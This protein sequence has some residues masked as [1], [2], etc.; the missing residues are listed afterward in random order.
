[1]LLVTFLFLLGLI[2]G[3][4][5]NVVIA[6][7]KT[8][9]KQNPKLS[10]KRSKCPHCG[11]V[12]AWYDNIPLL[13][14]ILLKGRCRHCGKKISWQ[15]PLVELVTA[16]LVVG[17]LV[18]DFSALSIKEI[19]ITTMTGVG[20]AF[21]IFQ[22]SCVFLMIG[23]LVA[24]F[25]YDLKHYLIPDR[26]VLVGVIATLIY[27]LL[28]DLNLVE[29]GL[30]PVSTGF[31]LNSAT[32]SGFL[33]ALIASGFFFCLVYFSKEKWMG[34]GD[35][36]L[37][38]FMGLVLGFPTIL[39]GLFIAYLTG[40]VVGVSL[41]AFKKKK[42]KSEIPFGPFLCLGTYIAL[43]FGRQIIVWYLKIMS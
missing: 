6:R 7:N 33:G 30:K 34:W 4:A 18:L 43:L 20:F 2:L 25:A 28:L 11:E 22:L 26:F 9:G 31:L 24:I 10:G 14:F 17:V 40:A 12:I 27:N 38:V 13:S 19:D 35:V 5:V 15:Y 1:M 42:M 29:T 23:S 16:L 36:K 21:W 41:L 37:A 39:I 3:S 32:S 8:A